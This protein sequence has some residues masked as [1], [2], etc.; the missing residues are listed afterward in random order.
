MTDMK[1]GQNVHRARKIPATVY[2]SLPPLISSGIDAAYHA[3]DRSLLIP[4]EQI[5]KQQIVT[6]Q[7]LYKPGIIAGARINFQGTR[8]NLRHERDITKVISFPSKHQNCRWEDNLSPDWSFHNS[9]SDPEPSSLFVANGTYDFSLE[10]F[11]EFREDFIQYL[12]SSETL[13]VEY[14][15]FFRLDR[16]MDESAESFSNRC[17]E[18]AREDLNQDMHQLEDTLQRQH[19]RLKQK[20]EREV[21][22]IGTS[23]SQVN[24][25]RRSGEL[26]VQEEIEAHDSKATM[27]NIKKEMNEL[28]R[29]REAKLKEF[30]EN[31]A[32][33]ANERETEI[34]RMNR[35]QIHVLQFGLIWLPYFEYVIQEED[36][37]RLELVKSF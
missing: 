32:G 30:E 26:D 21:R 16:K 37:R 2:S 10:H 18:K 11:E 24:S 1:G 17:M 35:G 36:S 15:P 20:L 13:K 29:V 8:W 23:P 5:W 27:E 9:R 28:S 25:T 34:F 33:L 19:D 12:V 31:L 22:D 6:S 4:F 14:N 7:I 3:L